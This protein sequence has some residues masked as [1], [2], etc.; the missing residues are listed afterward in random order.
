MS[1]RD[2]VQRLIANH[3][4]RLQK[5]KE[6][7]AIFGPH[8]PPY[9]SIEIEDTEA[10]LERLQTELAGLKGT[11]PVTEM[12]PVSPVASQ[13]F[14]AYSRRDLEF[15]QTLAADLERGGFAPWWDLSKLQ[16]GQNWVRQITAALDE[17]RHCLVVLSPDSVKSDWVLEEYTYARQIG[18]DI[19]PL[20][21]RECRLPL[22]LNT[23]HYFDF[24]R[25]EYAPTLS[26]LL[27]RLQPP[28]QRRPPAPLVPPSWVEATSP[29]WTKRHPAEPD[30]VLIP[31]GEFW[32]GSDRRQLEKA[33]VAWEDW[34]E[35][36]TPRHQLY[37]PDYFMARYPVTNAAYG[38]FI[39]DG[40]YNQPEFW[41]QTGWQRREEEKWTQPRLWADE[42]WNQPDCPVVGVSWYEAV[43]YCGWLARITSR[44]YRLPGEAEWEKAAGGPDGRIWPWGNTWQPERCNTREKGSGRTTPVGQYSP[45]GDSKYGLA[46]M[47]GNVWEWCATRWLK[48]YP[49]DVTENEW[50]GDYLAGDASRMLRGGSWFDVPR[51]A[52]VSY[53]NSYHPD[54]FG[55]DFGFRIIVAPV[56]P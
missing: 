23:L 16:G 51:F 34:M 52:R 2:D 32:L 3:Q 54:D 12:P 37:L 18:V 38:R 53:R 39:R 10:E 21:Y 41:T 11:P 42:K 14:L 19:I 31:A 22:G 8:T 30:M 27:L 49:Y 36:E 24:C 56:W 47:A 1:R 9:I 25:N 15:V 35:R 7:Q 17:S 50:T 28:E 29:I 6:Q 45:Q 33:G 55:Y 40:G 5:L 48:S 20:L 44:P 13:V 46:D 43:A 4:R 26:Q